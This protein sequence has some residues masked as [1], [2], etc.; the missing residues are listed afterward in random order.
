MLNRYF[1]VAMHFI[2]SSPGFML[3]AAFVSS[4]AVRDFT[5]VGSRV[6]GRVLLELF[7]LQQWKKVLNNSEIEVSYLF[8]LKSVALEVDRPSLLCTVAE[9]VRTHIVLDLFYQNY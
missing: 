2:S 1:M 9:K 8:Q 3:E 5:G 4:S 6:L 7:Q